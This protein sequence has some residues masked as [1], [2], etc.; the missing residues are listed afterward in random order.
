MEVDRMPVGLADAMTAEAEAR[1]PGRSAFQS[2]FSSSAGGVGA[3]TDRRRLTTQVGAVDGPGR[4]CSGS[5]M[6][7][8]RREPLASSA[9]TQNVH[10]VRG[11]YRSLRFV[12]KVQVGS[13]PS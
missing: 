12:G 10:A 11:V 5:P 4:R 3:V 1:T 7:G 9:E 2:P 6:R 13:W 8:R